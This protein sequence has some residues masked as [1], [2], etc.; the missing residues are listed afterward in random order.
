MDLINE[1]FTQTR[2]RIKSQVPAV[3]FIDFD[4]GQL[5][6]YDTPPVS[7]P[8][9]LID[10]SD[11]AFN[12][13]GDNENWALCEVTVK[14]A[15]EVYENTNH[16]TPSDDALNHSATLTAVMN[17]LRGFVFNN[18]DVFIKRR[19][20]RIPAQGLKVYSIVFNVSV[21]GDV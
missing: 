13:G 8:C 7:Y 3:R 17:A 4:N 10:V 5:E 15:F 14:L 21:Y 19:L 18:S 20:T 12:D 1:L 9:A 6:L 16:L 11:V 2:D